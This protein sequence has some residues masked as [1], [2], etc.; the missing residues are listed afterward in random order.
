[1]RMTKIAYNPVVYYKLQGDKDTEEK[2]GEDDFIIILQTQQQKYLLEKFGDKGVC[3]D[4]THGTTGYDFGLTTLLVIDEFSEGVPAAWC[5][6][7]H[8][9]YKFMK[10]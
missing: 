1:M 3:C 6:S 10:I 9:D 8:E 5:L 4:S 7:N 2:L